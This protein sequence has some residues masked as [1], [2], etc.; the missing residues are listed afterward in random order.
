MC[1]GVCVCVFITE[2]R[3]AIL[4]ATNDDGASEPGPAQD[5]GWGTQ[6]RNLPRALSGEGVC[7]EREMGCLALGKRG[8]VC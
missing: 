5:P 1:V 8:T 2:I 7:R 3:R 4:I 6:D